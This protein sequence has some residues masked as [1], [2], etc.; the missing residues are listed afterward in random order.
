MRACLMARL[1]ARLR[2]RG[3]EHAV[4]CARGRAGG[5]GVGAWVRGCSAYPELLSSRPG[6]SESLDNALQEELV[7]KTSLHTTCFFLNY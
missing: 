4:V 2:A 5:P 6:S 7:Q 1:D 3:V